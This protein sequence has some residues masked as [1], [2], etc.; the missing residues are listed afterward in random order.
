MNFLVYLVVT[1]GT[2]YLVRMLP[3]VLMRGRIKNRFLLSFLHYIP[4]A[5]LSVMTVPAIFTATGD[6]RTAAA[7]FADVVDGHQDAG[8]PAHQDH[9]V[10]G[11]G[12]AGATGG[13]V[14]LFGGGDVGRHV[15]AAQ[16]IAE[17]D[18]KD[19]LHGMYLAFYFLIRDIIA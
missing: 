15:G 7:G 12:I 9:G 5:V 3:L 1:A 16:N 10:A 17:Q 11:T 18:R 14:H 13:Q 2:T 8:P 6:V 19:V 4:Y